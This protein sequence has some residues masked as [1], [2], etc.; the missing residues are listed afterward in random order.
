MIG[1]PAGYSCDMFHHP[2]EHLPTQSIVLRS[3]IFDNLYRKSS[4]AINDR[5]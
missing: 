3:K 5:R 2:R 4:M 1:V